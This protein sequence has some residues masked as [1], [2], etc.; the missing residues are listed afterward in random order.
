VKD[1]INVCSGKLL[2]GDLEEEVNNF[3]KDTR[4]INKNDVY[5]GIK[6][7]NFDGNEFY[8]DAFD[9]GAN[10]CILD[11]DKIDYKNIDGKTIILVD[12]SIKAIQKLAIY[13]RSLYDIPVIA[14][15]GSVGKTSTRN[16]I[17]TVLSEKEGVAI[18]TAE[19]KTTYGFIYMNAYIDNTNSS[20]NIID[21]K[22]KKKKYFTYVNEHDIYDENYNILDS[23]NLLIPFS[24]INLVENLFKF[25]ELIVHPT[26]C[27]F[28][29][30]YKQ[31]PLI[32]D[33]GY[34]YA[35]NINMK[36][37]RI[38]TV[39]LQR[40]FN[41]IVPYIPQTNI[42]NST[43][44]LKYKDYKYVNTDVNYLNDVFYSEDINIYN[45]NRLKVY[46]SNG[47]Y[48]MFEPIE[49]KHL[50]SSKLINLSEEFEII[51]KGTHTYEE[52]IELEKDEYVFE[53]FKSYVR[54]NELNAYNEDEILFL[55][56]RYKI[57]Y[58]TECIGLNAVKT[59]KLY[60]L[61]YKFTL[62]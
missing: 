57:E 14:V 8:L 1:I 42:I 37:N 54:E 31:T 9:K 13:K 40:Y 23:F 55:F 58:D 12:N 32:D 10:V 15:T 19:H 39:T 18:G 59:Q 6:G 3:S 61:T 38:D 47:S 36:P 17:Y 20:F 60:T 51:E 46:D 24:N 11:N 35:Y 48:Q 43:Y 41:N 29:T 34:T 44:C 26:K 33:A 30:Y 45:Y 27:V 28:N 56:N 22:Y 53:K 16:I 5:V 21:T 7:D 50:N 25:D 62:L 4:T 49:Y 2:F 52:L